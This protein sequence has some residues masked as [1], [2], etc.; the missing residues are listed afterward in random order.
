[1][2]EAV[3]AAGAGPDQWLRAAG[4]P[5]ILWR[6]SARRPRRHISKSL[7][8]TGA[9]LECA[10]PRRTA[11]HSAS[12][13]AWPAASLRSVCNNRQVNTRQP[14]PALL[15]LSCCHPVCPVLKVTHECHTT[16]QIVFRS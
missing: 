16:L 7:R 10:T 4:F 9:G 11:P 1:M 8:E 5:I 3:Q 14:P 15:L 6:G 2:G 12:I 13:P